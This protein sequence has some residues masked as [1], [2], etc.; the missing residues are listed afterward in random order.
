MVH[1]RFVTHTHCGS[2][3]LILPHTHLH[4]VLVGILPHSYHYRSH[5]L[6]VAHSSVLPTTPPHFATFY[7]PAV[8]CT[9]GLHWVLG[10]RLHTHTHTVPTHYVLYGSHTFARTA[11]HWF[12]THTTHTFPDGYTFTCTDR[13]WMGLHTTRSSC[14]T[15]LPVWITHLSPHYHGSARV[16][17]HGLHTFRSAPA[18]FRLPHTVPR[19]YTGSTFCLRL[20]LGSCTNTIPTHWVHG[21]ATRTTPHVH[22]F[23]WLHG[24]STRSFGPFSGSFYYRLRSV[25][26]VHTFWFTRTY[27]SQDLRFSLRSPGSHTCTF[28]H[29]THYGSVPH[30]RSATHAVLRVFWLHTLGSH[31][32]HAHSHHHL[33]VPFIPAF[34]HVVHY[35][36]HLCLHHGFYGFTFYWIHARSAAFTPFVCT[37]TG[38][39]TYT[40]TCT[41]PHHTGSLHTQEDHTHLPRWFHTQFPHTTLHHVPRFVGLHTWLLHTHRFVYYSSWVPHVHVW[42]SRWVPKFISTPRCTRWLHVLVTPHGYTV[43]FTAHTTH[44]PTPL[45]H[46]TPAHTWFTTVTL[47]Y[48]P[49]HH[50]SAHSLY[51]TTCHTSRFAHTH[52]RIHFTTPGFVHTRLGSL[53]LHGSRSFHSYGCVPGYTWFL[54]HFSFYFCTLWF[55]FGSAAYTLLVRSYRFTRSAH[56]SHRTTTVGP[57]FHFHTVLPQFSSLVHGSRSLVGYQ[58]TTRFTFHRFYVYLYVPHTHHI[59]HGSIHTWFIST[60]HTTTLRTGFLPFPTGFYTLVFTFSHAYC[61]HTCHIHRFCIHTFSLDHLGSHISFSLYVGYHTH[62]TFTVATARSH[63]LSQFLLGPR[64]LHSLTL[65]HAQFLDRSV[66]TGSRACRH[67]P[68][69]FWF[70][71]HSG[72]F[73]HYVLRSGFTTP[74]T[75]T[76]THWFGPTH[77]PHTHT[78]TGFYTAPDLHG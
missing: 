3:G 65:V 31:H 69:H 42:F 14:H 50:S 18:P 55:T 47:H 61:S 76:H 53:T 32:L 26:L 39:F 72:S 2:V 25:P 24:Y 21:S 54:P 49:A 23:G 10:S 5:T 74:H 13:S 7:T 12:T 1:Y 62:V 28:S 27:T 38:W 48:S 41:V 60:V 63:C 36:T 16:H 22:T 29:T 70:W 4:T 71:V 67:P 37:P 52:L 51:T 68:V 56:G 59:S 78:P 34:T 45:D 46:T 33:Y 75:H 40:H 64:T 19:F 66:L 6:H 9:P 73:A 8:C 57:G 17:V 58:F 15:H 43:G 35:H 77:L 11:P 30:T 20:P 44:T